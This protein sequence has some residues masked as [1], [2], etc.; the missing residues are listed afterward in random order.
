[1]RKKKEKT[2]EGRLER[3]TMRGQRRE[4]KEPDKKMRI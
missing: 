4:K 1:M 2:E 3:A